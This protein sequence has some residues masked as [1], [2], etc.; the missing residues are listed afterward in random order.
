[1]QHVKDTFGETFYRNLGNT[2][3]ARG[4]ACYMVIEALLPDGAGARGA[5]SKWFEHYAQRRAVLTEQVRAEL[6][7][8]GQA[9]SEERVAELIHAR[10]AAEDSAG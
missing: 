8:R 10:L 5:V 7:A 3:A 1:M 2:P 9:A 6:A 4:T